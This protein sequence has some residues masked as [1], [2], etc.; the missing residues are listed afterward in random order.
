MYAFTPQVFT[1]TE[2]WRAEV[3]RTLRNA[4]ER[5]LTLSTTLFVVAVAV[6]A[7]VSYP[8]VVRNLNA[9]IKRNRSLLLL[10][11]GDVIVGVKALKDTITALT[12][13][14]NTA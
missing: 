7:L 13:R 3:P 12:K 2:S 4:T 10:L 14:L 11:P 1:T 6:C 8:W 9:S 5:T